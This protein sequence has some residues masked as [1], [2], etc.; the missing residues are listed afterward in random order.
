MLEHSSQTWKSSVYVRRFNAQL[1][2]LQGDQT[3]NFGSSITISCLKDFQFF[4]FCIDGPGE[5]DKL[6]IPGPPFRVSDL[7]SLKW[8]VRICILISSPGESDAVV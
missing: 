3:H 5:L 1:S 6:Q 2:G 8:G 4:F 7:A